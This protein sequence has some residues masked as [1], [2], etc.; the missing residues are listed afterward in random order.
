MSEP[1]RSSR[2]WWICGLLLLASAVNY[3]DRLTLAS[4]SRRLIDELQLSN[5]DYGAV[6]QYF[7]YA[8]AVGAIV[9]GLLADRVSVRWLYPVV[10]ALWSLMGFLT[11]MV[12]SAGAAGAIAPLSALLFCRTLLGFFE[13]GHWPCALRTTQQLLEPE[14][15]SF[16]NSILQSGTS[17][18]AIVTPIIVA[19][20]LT[21][22][23]GSWRRPFSWIGALGLVWVLGWLWATRRGIGSVAPAASEDP[24]PAEWAASLAKVLRSHRFWLLVVVVCCING[25]YSV[26]RVWLPLALQDPAG[27]GFSEQ[28]T[29]GRI[30]P[31]YYLVNDVGC[32]AAGAATL[33]LHR[34]GVSAV[35]ARRWVFTVSGALLAPAALLPAVARGEWALP[36]VSA[37][38]ASMAI[39]L[40][41]SLG[42]LAVFPCY[43][44]FTQDLSRRHIGLVTG[45]L[46]FFAW[47]IP[48]TAQRVLGEFID[49]SGS[50]D[51][52]FQVAAWPVL[53]AA[54]ALWAL[55]NI[56]WLHPAQ[57]SGEPRLRSTRAA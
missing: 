25:V 40:M 48:S 33:W 31:L 5:A 23:A 10:L 6:E 2:K 3:M 46:S 24:E 9:F 39:L 57:G 1:G 35:N 4:V 42:S 47:I 27:L 53:V 41:T 11:G 45:L 18:G 26:Y 38:Q 17:V 32:L 36:G 14:D 29:L 16:G 22:A 28:Q 7:G 43:Y 44:A 52:A 8:F 15:R 21:P 55:W 20:M 51:I 49:R 13:S 30:L 50:Y 56:E 12:P 19:A 34:H 54:V 37:G